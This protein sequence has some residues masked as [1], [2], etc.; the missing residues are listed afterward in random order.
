MKF[1]I[2]TL[3]CR[4][5]QAESDAIASQLIARGN[6]LTSAQEADLVIVNSCTV[7]GEAEHK[8]RKTVRSLLKKFDGP[9]ILTGCA[10]NIA[11]DK[12]LEIDN[13]IICE[14]DKTKVAKLAATLAKDANKQNLQPEKRARRNLKIQDGCDNACTFCI[15]H[16][17]RGKAQSVPS[18]E[19][20][21]QAKQF[22][23]E[24]AKEIILTGIDLGAYNKPSL[25][26]L[27]QQLLDN[28]NIERIRLS[29]IEP[30][31]INDELIDLLANSDGR[32]CRYLHIPLQS[33]SDKVLKEMARKYNSE[34]YLELINKLKKACPEIAI[35]TDVIVGFPGESDEDFK[36]TC[37]LV[38]KAQ[39]M[40][41][42][43]FRYSKRENTPA[44]A[45]TDQIDP[46]IKAARAKELA[47]IGDKLASEDLLLRKGKK[48]LMVV[49]QKR[50]K[51]CIG[52]TESFH[53]IK[54]ENNAKV[55]DLIEITL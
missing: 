6:I 50:G 16:V 36:Q 38:Q 55:G 9:L 20:I 42:H 4:V 34:Q 7:T 1:Y 46:T 3:G 10:V 5:N 49:E 44:A 26:A 15:V 37:S 11:K 54:V 17:A 14:E 30:Q 52:T 31:S 24:G 33:G 41:L 39:F 51:L 12:Y 29:S 27:I 25:S 2:H 53:S 23:N 19:V 47:S 22:I 35:S 18:E 28:T 43:I 8:N 40:K 48:E 13:R 21:A 32:L 45:R